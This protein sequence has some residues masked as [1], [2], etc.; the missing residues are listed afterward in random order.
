MKNVNPRSTTASPG[1]ERPGREQPSPRVLA[2]VPGRA[3]GRTLDEVMAAYREALAVF[4]KNA[5][6][7]ISYARLMLDQA[8]RGR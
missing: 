2:V 5:G 4:D 8:R 7:I 3:E 1:A 6:A